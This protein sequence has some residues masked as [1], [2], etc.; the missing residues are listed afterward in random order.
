[1][2][3]AESLLRSAAQ[4]G[5]ELCLANP[6]TTEMPLVAALDAG[7]SLRVVLGLFEGVC[8][9][10][11]D[12]YARMADRPALTLLHL[13]PG[14]ANGLANLHNA[15]RARSPL[16]NLVGDHATWHRAADAP[17]TSDIESLARP[18]SGWVRTSRSARELPGDFA[19]AFEAAG[20]GQVA[21][22]VVPADCQW[23]EAGGPVRPRRAAPPAEVPANRVAAA[24]E[25]LR[26]GRPAAVLLGG[27][28]L[29]A[30]GPRAAARVAAATGARLVS[31]TFPSRQER[32]Q[33]L[34]ATTRLPYFPEPAMQ[35]LAD[36][37]TLVLA[38]APAPVAFFGYPGVP[39]QLAREGSCVPLADPAEDVVRALEDLAETLDAP[40]DA[41]PEPAPEI[42][43]TRSGSL[44]PG[45]LGAAV[46]ATQPE[47]AIVVDEALTSGGSWWNLADAAAP[48]TTLT[49]TGGAIGQGLPCATGAALACPDR[50]VIA[51][52]ADG[53]GLYTLQAL[54]TQAR[55]GLNVVTVICA[56]R[57]YRILQIEMARAGIAEPGRRA[58]EL[59]ALSDPEMSWVQLAAGFGVPAV[60]V[61]TAEALRPALARALAEPGPSL[62]EALL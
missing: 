26:K 53:S 42:P 16:V 1:M 58:R 15:R 13:G 11:A 25:R 40:R 35:L 62:I 44:D 5:V 30:P 59:T 33:G 6:G 17:L 21:T 27:H 47:G 56:N 24:A 22:L 31:E 48:H 39:S 36:F 20:P 12:G 49:L 60:R 2:N 18:V 34:P 29:R 37:E 4:A 46:A 28:A 8:T 54:W 45:Q 43:A 9:G 10:A 52:Q 51:L 19:A 61:E 23:D 14:L 3:G 7:A 38:G 32:G 50:P 55:E 57:H 41:A